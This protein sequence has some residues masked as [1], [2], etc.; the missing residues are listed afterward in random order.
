MNGGLVASVYTL[1]VSAIVAAVSYWFTKAKDHDEDLR[2]L[3]FDFY[4]EFV[5]AFAQMPD[6]HATEADRIRFNTATNAM[7]LVG[8]PEVLKA[9][10]DFRKAIGYKNELVGEQKQK[11]FIE[12]YRKLLWVIRKDLK[13]PTAEDLTAFSAEYWAASPPEKAEV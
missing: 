13:M 9:L 12:T 6:E 7:Y 5:V 4:R 11:Q 1:A 3:R 10:S 8:T 2:K